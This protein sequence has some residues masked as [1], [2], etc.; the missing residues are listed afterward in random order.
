MH[1]LPSFIASYLVN[2][3][4]EVVFVA[5]AGWL[6]C[7]LLNRLGPQAEHIGWI[8]TLFA[9]LIAPALPLVRWLPRLFPALPAAAHGLSVTLTYDAPDV[10]LPKGILVLPGGVSLALSLFYLGS[11]IF[12]AA[13]LAA[14]L[15]R[16]AVLRSGSHPASLTPRQDEIWQRCMRSFSLRGVRVL[17]ASGITGPVTLGI[18]AP[19]LLLPAAF[20]TECS[21][22]DLLT[23]L[24]HEC[25]HIK[26]HD[27]LKNLVFEIAGV[28]L[29]FHPVIWMIKARIAQTREILCDSMVTE[30]IIDPRIYARSLLRLA[31]RMALRSQARPAQAI[32]IFDANILEKRIM[33]INSKRRS[34]GPVARFGLIVPAAL[35]IL[36]TSLAA[37]AFAIDIQPASQSG[38]AQ[39]SPYGPVYKIG[40]GVSA[41]TIVH[42]Q[43]AKY[44]ASALRDKPIIDCIVVVGLIVD[45]TGSPKDVHVVKSFRKDFDEEAMKAVRH[46][47]FKPAMKNRAP[48][49][50]AINVE[51][52]FR[53]YK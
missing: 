53:A 8:S 50:V 20:A 9:A 41:P 27:F 18:R 3:L 37:S 40:P 21:D 32:G 35:C 38:Q 6:A 46:Y 29:A 39:N 7:R 10:A 16:A 17:V 30:T 36:F 45:K 33:I 51:V 44:P 12:F 24:A 2:S 23:A 14:S 11:L 52:N 34:I 43:D 19:A 28:L 47:E 49:A 31:E 42:A 1:N 4:W 26:R 5:G 48:V 25:A 15:H 22:Q 13:L